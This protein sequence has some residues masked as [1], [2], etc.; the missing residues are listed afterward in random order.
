MRIFSIFGAFFSPRPS[1]DRPIRR[2]VRSHN[3]SRPKGG[4]TSVRAYDRRGSR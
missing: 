4:T 2:Q 1:A 3:R